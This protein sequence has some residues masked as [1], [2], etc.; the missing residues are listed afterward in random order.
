MNT[1]S[2]NPI[3]KWF[4]IEQSCDFLEKKLN[5]EVLRSDLEQLC[6]DGEIQLHVK[7]KSMKVIEIN[8]N[9]DTTYFEKIIPPVGHCDFN[10]LPQDL[11]IELRYSINPGQFTV[12]PTYK[13]LEALS[14]D[15]NTFT[16]YHDDLNRT[17]FVDFNT[18]NLNSSFE[19]CVKHLNHFMNSD[20]QSTVSGV[21]LDRETDK[22]ELGFPRFALEQFVLR[23]KQSGEKKLKSR[24][25]L[26]LHNI[27]FALI[28]TLIDKSSKLEKDKTND[29]KGKPPF[30]SR[31]QLIEA[32]IDQGWGDYYGI[33]RSNLENK[34]AEI[35]KHHKSEN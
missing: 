17:G 10:N 27:I 23:Y 14:F 30:R 33:S 29:E 8:F 18:E 31:E 28:E 9:T 16:L 5:F 19:I 11:P 35:L 12:L 21:I 32:L 3:R 25:L 7:L 26:S 20:K 4:T 6:E 22:F 24:E 15:T 13:N 2:I 34:F 1:K